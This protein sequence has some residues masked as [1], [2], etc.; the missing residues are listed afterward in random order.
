MTEVFLLEFQHP[1]L[2]RKSECSKH[3]FL[4]I[5]TSNFFL[6]FD[7]SENQSYDIVKMLYYIVVSKNIHDKNLICKNF[8][9]PYWSFEQLIQRFLPKN[10]KPQAKQTISSLHKFHFFYTF[11]FVSI[12][13]F[14]RLV[15]YAQK[16]SCLRYFFKMSRLSL[17]CRATK[18]YSIARRKVNFL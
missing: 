6:L 1:N 18:G 8:Q 2:L 16:C 14:W 12:N 4:Y 5:S 17:L 7:G 13:V 11:D 15:N 10:T 3:I 9:N